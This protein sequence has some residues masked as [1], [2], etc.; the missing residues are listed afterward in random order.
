MK[1]KLKNFLPYANVTRTWLTNLSVATFAVGLL[2]GNSWGMLAGA[3]LLVFAYLVVFFEL[4]V[5]K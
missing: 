5:N 1:E 3:I 4:R 2:D